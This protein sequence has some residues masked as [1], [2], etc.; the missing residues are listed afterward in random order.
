MGMRSWFNDL[1]NVGDTI[2]EEK[3]GKDEEGDR[4]AD[5]N[6]GTAYICAVSVF[7]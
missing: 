3:E 5:S 7:I 4:K 2:I 6:D 1:C